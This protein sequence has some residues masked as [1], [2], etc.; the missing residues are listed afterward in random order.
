MLNIVIIMLVS[1]TNKWGQLENLMLC[2]GLTLSLCRMAGTLWFRAPQ[3]LLPWCTMVCRVLAES[4]RF[5]RASRRYWLLI[6]SSWTSFSC[7]S[8]WKAWQK[9]RY[10][11]K[12]FNI[13]WKEEYQS[14]SVQYDFNILSCALV[15]LNTCVCVHFG[16]YIR[17]ILSLVYC[18][19]VLTGLVFS[20]IQCL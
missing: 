2:G 12:P 9:S 5:S 8:L 11:S 1:N 18:L 17:P 7:T 10:D 19:T 16:F 4:V 15:S 13:F 20:Y 6:I 14:F 3:R